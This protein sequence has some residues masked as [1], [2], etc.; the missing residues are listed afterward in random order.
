[1]LMS[2]NLLPTFKLHSKLRQITVVD[3][4]EMIIGIM[5]HHAKSG[6]TGI[7]E[8]FE[9]VAG[10]RKEVQLNTQRV[11]SSRVISPVVRVDYNDSELKKMFPNALKR[12]I[13][14]DDEYNQACLCT[15]IKIGVGQSSGGE[16]ANAEQVE[17]SDDG[18]NDA[19]DDYGDSY[20]VEVLETD[21]QAQE[22]IKR[23]DDLDFEGMGGAYRE[24]EERRTLADSAECLVDPEPSDE[25]IADSVT[26]DS[27]SSESEPSDAASSES[28]PSDAEDESS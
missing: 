22:R 26:S 2:D 10:L 21:E 16:I 9:D 18:G 19:D 20:I 17:D 27:A 3:D 11:P 25:D 13:G 6:A 14:H 4:M 23:Q 7:S 15:N 1:M 12:K 5:I 28:E 8:I 24:E